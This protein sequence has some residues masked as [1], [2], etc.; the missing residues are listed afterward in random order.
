MVVK[1]NSPLRP[2]RPDDPE[3]SVALQPLLFCAEI[4][5]L[6]RVSTGT[7]YAIGGEEPCYVD[8]LRSDCFF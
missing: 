1:C 8:A 5:A 4:A 6:L 7:F 3:F 2:R